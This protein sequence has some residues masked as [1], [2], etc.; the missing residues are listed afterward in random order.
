MMVNQLIEFSCE[1]RHTIRTNF[2]FNFFF[3]IVRGIHAKQAAIEPFMFYLYF[4]LHIYGK[5]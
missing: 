5:K 4:Q 1:L 2:K 3:Q